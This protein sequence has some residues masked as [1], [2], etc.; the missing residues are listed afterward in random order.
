M[1]T[2]Q[3]LNC[4]DTVGII[5]PARK[6]SPAEIEFSINT[7]QSW[8]LKVKLGK[9]IFGEHHQFS[10]SDK[11]RTDDFNDMIYDDDIKAIICARG[12]YG[13]IRII[14]KIDFA[15]FAKHPKWIVG[16]SDITCLHSHINNLFNIET[17]H[18]IMPINFS[19]S[20]EIGLSIDSLKKTL[21]GD[22]IEYITNSHEFNKKGSA[23][24]QLTGGNLS[25]LYALSAT[26]SDIITDDKILFI[27]DIDEYLYHIDR[28]MLNLKRSGKLKNLKGLI[29]GGMTGMNDNEIPF[30]YTAQEIIKQT[31]QEYDY[32]VCFDFPA[33]HQ[34]LNLSLIMG[35]NV[36]LIVKNNIFVKF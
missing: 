16:Y 20:Y 32:P 11:Q 30:G 28:M 34:P 14:D 29:V 25:I 13:T 35:R 3:Y 2:P 5:A 10:G 19:D 15:H 26:S 12:G 21:F 33:G 22:T 9:N 7:F 17:I 24:G 31:V 27:E 1:I 36:D 23:S 8:G 4:G 6:L 18:A